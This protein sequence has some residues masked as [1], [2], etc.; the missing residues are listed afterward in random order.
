M[1]GASRNVHQQYS[2]TADLKS[3][4]IEQ[5]KGNKANIGVEKNI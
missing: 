3:K 2:K 4:T 5:M 1:S